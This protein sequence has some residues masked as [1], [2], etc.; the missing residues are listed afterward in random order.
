MDAVYVLIGVVFFTLA[1][2][3]GAA[4]SRRANC[5]RHQ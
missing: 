3:G 4:A 2:N 1:T 5:A